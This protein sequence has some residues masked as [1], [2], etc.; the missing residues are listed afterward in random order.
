MDKSCSDSMLAYCAYSL[1]IFTSQKY[2]NI[3]NC[4]VVMKQ[5]MIIGYQVACERHLFCFATIFDVSERKKY[6]NS[7][8][9]GSVAKC[10]PYAYQ[11]RAYVCL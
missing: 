10:L 11:I 6:Q 2:T 7:I 8:L 3:K 9:Q 4:A 5:S 1:K